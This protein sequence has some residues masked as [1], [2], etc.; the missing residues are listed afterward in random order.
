M[1]LRQFSENAKRMTREER[2]AEAERLLAE[3]DR[4]A[5]EGGLVGDQLV[6]T[7]TLILRDAYQDDPKRLAEEV[8]KVRAER[9]AQLAARP[10]IDHGPD[11][12][13]YKEREAEVL[14]EVL[15]MDSYPEGLD[16]DGYLAKRLAKVRAEVYGA[17][18]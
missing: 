1:S 18:E 15:A 14:R 11:Y 6:F 7:K 2:Q 4:L 12:A 10:P 5:A 9:E 16:R 8:A 13:R 3:A 17:G